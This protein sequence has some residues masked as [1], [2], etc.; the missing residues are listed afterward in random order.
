VSTSR[1]G[2]A[3]HLAG[4]KDNWC[5]YAK[6][7]PSTEDWSKVTC[8]S[9]LNYGVLPFVRQCQ[10]SLSGFCRVLQIQPPRDDAPLW[11]V[12]GM[13]QLDLLFYKLVLAAFLQAAPVDLP[14]VPKVTMDLGGDCGIALPRYARQLEDFARRWAAPECPESIATASQ[15]TRDLMELINDE[16][17]KAL[18]IPS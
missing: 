9:C 10:A 5:Q 1:H 17:R 14:G 16:A 18:K 8:R 3:V 2:G 4:A 11:K 7:Y 13:E 15:D 6:S 12:T